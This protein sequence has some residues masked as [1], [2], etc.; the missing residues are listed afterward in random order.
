MFP[1][2]I[3]SSIGCYFIL[4]LLIAWITSRNADNQSYFLA[5]KSA[6][7]YAVAFGM[8]SDSLSGVTFISVPGAVGASQFSYLQLVF[9]Y[10]FG[11]IVISQVL[12]PLYYRMNLT[13][14]YSYLRERFGIFAQ[15]TGSF[16][17]LLSRLL[18][19]A[20]R[21]Y[22]TATI[23]QVFVFDKMFLPYKIPFSVSVTLI[24][25][26]ILLY[27]YKG[28]I[29]T[30]VWTDVFQSTFLLAGVVLSIAA[31]S[32]ELDFSFSRII[33]AV[34]ESEYA[35]T[36]FWDINTKSFFPK[37]FLGGMFIAIAMTGLDQNMMQKNLACRTLIDAQKNI[38]WFSVV[39][40]TVN[41]LFLSL[42]VLLYL[43]ASYKGISLPVNAENGKPI[44]DYLFPTLALEHLGTFA[45]IMFIV[46]LTAAT[47][48]SA[49]SVLTTLTTSFMIDILGK[50]SENDEKRIKRIRHVIHIVFA[51]LLLGTILGFK[52]LNKQAIID[53]VLFL[54]T[55]TYGPLLGLFFFGI[56]SKRKVI[57]KFIPI[58]CL[59]SPIICYLLNKYSTIWFNGYAFGNELLLV[60]GLITFAGLYLISQNDP[61]TVQ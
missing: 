16:F 60:N 3:L 18:G 32:K 40:V 51:L 30:L 49:D 47:F 39:M 14:I 6:P 41:I 11:Y 44:T 38:R 21:L 46:G 24:I 5:N 27:T 52:A 29:K 19:A 43:Y 17:F 8:L 12:L 31:I 2:F 20:A 28:G 36:F 25:A 42:G 1:V 35:K 23:I 59:I 50:K 48:S 55:L 10:F 7:W 26:L 58:I 37:Q 22:L 13:S 45:A 34:T 61:H 15:R 54:A 57:D 56:L 4:L 53:T 9:G 33:M